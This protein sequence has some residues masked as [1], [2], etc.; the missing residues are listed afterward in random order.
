FLGFESEGRTFEVVIQLGAVLAV[1]SV[2]AAK[3]WQVFSTAPSSAESRRFILAVLLAFLPAV[4]VGVLARDFIKGV[5]FES[6]RLIASM[7]ILGGI[8]LLFV[9][10]LALKP[11]FD[12]VEDI[13]VWRAVM[14]GCIQ[15]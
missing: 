12:R 3:I 9:D 15:C 8:V 6:P 11:R 4:F 2:Y 13:P 1:L 5:L 14:I 10:R 7:L